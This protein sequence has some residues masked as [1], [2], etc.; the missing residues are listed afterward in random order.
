[1][2]AAIRYLSADNHTTDTPPVKL[3]NREPPST[4][5]RA[6]F[7]GSLF[8]CMWPSMGICFHVLQMELEEIFLQQFSVY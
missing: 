6:I 1:M 7:E 2:S 3:V 4:Y 8:L 5:F